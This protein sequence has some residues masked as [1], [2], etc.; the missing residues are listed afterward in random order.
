LANNINPNTFIPDNNSEFIKKADEFAL[1]TMLSLLQHLIE[2]N[3]RGIRKRIGIL[4]KLRRIRVRKKWKI[5]KFVVN[6]S[7]QTLIIQLQFMIFLNDFLY[8]Q[9]FFLRIYISGIFYLQMTFAKQFLVIISSKNY[10]YF[11]AT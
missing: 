1:K 8:L 4:M 7:K 9:D 11:Y 5:L 6:Y 3:L 2:C 10:L